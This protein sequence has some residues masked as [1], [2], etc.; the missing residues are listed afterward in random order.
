M[1]RSF[2]IAILGCAVCALAACTSFRNMAGLNKIPPDEFAVV[3]KAPLIIPPDYNLRPPTP[4][5]AP[6]NE[7]PPTDAAAAA[8]FGNQQQAA[9]G[10]RLPAGT[11]SRA[12]QTL[13]A[14]AHVE[15][16]NPGIRQIINSDEAA[17]QGADESFTNSLLF[18][19]EPETSDVPVDPSNPN[20]APAGAP[21]T[22]PQEDSGGWF[23][24]VPWF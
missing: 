16:A 6:I 7:L 5:A 14:D 9:T 19:R 23:D 2:R 17:M 3:S 20:G 12:E 15:R 1:T 4:G 22:Q 13:M 21:Q 24:W 8:L 10:A 11:Y 18:W